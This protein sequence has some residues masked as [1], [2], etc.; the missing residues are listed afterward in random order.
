MK[1]N[2]MENDQ[3]GKECDYYCGN[4]QSF[5]VSDFRKVCHLLFSV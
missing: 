2:K 5:E 4:N 1:L 3:L